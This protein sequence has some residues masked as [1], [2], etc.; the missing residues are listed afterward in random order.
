MHKYVKIIIAIAA[1]I[2]GYLFGYIS[3]GGV[4]NFGNPTNTIL[5][6]CSTPLI[7]GGFVYF[8]IVLAKRKKPLV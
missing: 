7:I 8:I 1:I 6:C 2:L 5:F 3:W 4:Y